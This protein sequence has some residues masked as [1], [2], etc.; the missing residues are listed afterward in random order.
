[1]KIC[2]YCDQPMDR[3]SEERNATACSACFS[4]VKDVRRFVEVCDEFKGTIHYDA[5]LKRRQ[6]EAL[7]NDQKG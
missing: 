6:Q 4:K 1:M 3:T 2:K 5:I 7:E